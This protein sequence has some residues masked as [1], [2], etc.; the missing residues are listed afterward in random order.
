MTTV[1]VKGPTSSGLL[2]AVKIGMFSS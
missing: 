2:I 1:G